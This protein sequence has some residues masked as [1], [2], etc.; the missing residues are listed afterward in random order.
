MIGYRELLGAI[1]KAAAEI[2][3]MAETEEHV[4]ELE[5]EMYEEINLVAAARIAELA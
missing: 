5:Q 3:E 4:C 2:F 1:E